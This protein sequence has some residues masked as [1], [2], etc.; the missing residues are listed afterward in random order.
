MQ[1]TIC[2]AIAVAHTFERPPN[3]NNDYQYY[4]E[5][6]DAHLQITIHVIHF[7][8]QAEQRATS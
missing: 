6:N 5:H 7:S 1:L 4:K 8:P 3:D 2:L